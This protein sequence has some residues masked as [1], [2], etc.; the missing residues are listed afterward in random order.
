M[1]KQKIN[2]KVDFLIRYFS[3]PL[4]NN[5]G[6]ALAVILSISLILM[7]ICAG[8]T[9][10]VR[11]RI[12][13]AQKLEN[14]SQAFLKA[15]SGFNQVMYNILT[16]SFEPYSIKVHRTDGSFDKWNLYGKP[17]KLNPDV[18]IKLRDIAGMIPLLY[19]HDRLKKLWYKVAADSGKAA[20]FID[21]F[22]DW[23][24]KDKLKRLNG[25][26]A[27]EYRKAGYQYE[28]K[29]NFIQF[30]EEMKLMLGFD[31]D[32]YKTIMNSVSYR[33]CEHRNYLTMDKQT[34]YAFIG[35][36]NIVDTII[37]LRDK[38]ILTP[39]MFANMTGI[40]SFMP[41][42]YSPSNEIVIKIR[43]QN[44]SSVNSILA[45]VKKKEKK[46]APFKILEWR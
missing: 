33:G 25:A 15:K 4:D 32:I 34:L 31:S 17:I 37:D 27:W 23:Q 8:I 11:S 20:K 14:R 22:L 3:L 38:N 7:I 39:T 41:V 19:G 12:K 43:A 2:L 21:S 1:L 10:Q 35:N 24:D 46:D 6:Y 13:S 42:V 18:T 16:S 5:R 44:E 28:P 45:I 40:P 30:P 29:N 36:Q 26:E 9:S